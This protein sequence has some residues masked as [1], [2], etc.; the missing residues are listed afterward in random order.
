MP[1]FTKTVKG[2]MTTEGLAGIDYSAIVD[3]PNIE[4]MISDATTNTEGVIYQELAKKLDATDGKAA[5]SVLFGGQAP[6]YY[7]KAEDLGALEEELGGNVSDAISNLD[8][9]KAPNNHASADKTYGV[10]TEGTYG[11]VRLS[12]SVVS[13]LGV[14]EGTAATPAAVKLAYDYADSAHEKF[15]DYNMKVYTSFEQLGF[16]GIRG[17]DGYLND[18]CPTPKQVFDKMP[19]YSMLVLITNTDNTNLKNYWTNMPSRKGF[20]ELVKVHYN[21]STSTGRSRLTYWDIDKNIG[22]I[23]STTANIPDGV[24]WNKMLTAADF[25]VSESSGKYTLTINLD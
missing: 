16:T 7:A 18:N 22:Y 4:Q 5:D 12:D 23:S 3:A 21:T 6:E 20:I 15:V 10:G 9:N 2:I 1:Q 14:G 11:H 17:S 13:T 25:A 24:T 8:K 19:E